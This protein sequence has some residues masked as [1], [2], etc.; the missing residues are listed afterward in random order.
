MSHLIDM[1]GQRFGKLTVIEKAAPNTKTP[2]AYWRCVCD[3]GNEKVVVGTALRRGDYQSCG[4]LRGE[5][6]KRVHLEY[7]KNDPDWKKKKRESQKSTPCP[8]NEGVQCYQKDC[9]RCG[10]NP[11]VAE[12]RNKRLEVGHGT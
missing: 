10:W 4:C 11:K 12:V 2:G 8:Y 3:C 5:N 6:V 9:W 1:T 7:L